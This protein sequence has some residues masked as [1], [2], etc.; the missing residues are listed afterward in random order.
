MHGFTREF[1]DKAIASSP[2]ATDVFLQDLAGNSFTSGPFLAILIAVFLYIPALPAVPKG[3]PLQ[4]AVA[5]DDVL[6]MVCGL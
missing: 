5:T 1:M 2:N 4:S 6:D 3:Q